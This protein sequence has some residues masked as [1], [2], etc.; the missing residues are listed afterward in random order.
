[1]ILVHTSNF[2]NTKLNISVK[3]PC[4]LPFLC[5]PRQFFPS[6]KQYWKQ[7]S[8]KLIVHCLIQFHVKRAG[9]LAAIVCFNPWGVLRRVWLE[10]FLTHKGT[11]KVAGRIVHAQLQLTNYYLGP[12]CS[13][14]CFL[15]SSSNFLICSGMDLSRAITIKYAFV[16]LLDTFW[17][18]IQEKKAWVDIAT[19]QLTTWW[20]CLH[21]TVYCTFD[22]PAFN[23]AIGSLSF[24]ACN[25]WKDSQLPESNKCFDAWV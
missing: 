2:P 16:R 14:T 8:H 11:K 24:P 3:V 22:I 1:M 17:S 5:L 13:S 19:R 23:F 7:H 18:P 6:W 10:L 25:M 9:L 15:T 4:D 21:C 20:A 12:L